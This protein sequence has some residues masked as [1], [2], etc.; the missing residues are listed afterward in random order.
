[1]PPESQ[2][3]IGRDAVTLFD[4]ATTQ[5]VEAARPASCLAAFFLVKAWNERGPV[6]RTDSTH[7]SRR[8]RRGPGERVPADLAP[9]D[10]IGAKTQRVMLP[11]EVPPGNRGWEKSLL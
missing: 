2:A 5:R 10:L 7:R 3:R 1:M 6:D 8:R 4:A 11:D 9:G